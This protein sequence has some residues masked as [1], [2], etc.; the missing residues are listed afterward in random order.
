[1]RCEDK[2]DAMSTIVEEVDLAIVSFLK[3]AIHDSVAV[4][5]EL[6]LPDGDGGTKAAF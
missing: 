4:A 1:M 5:I 6:G 3:L 2:L